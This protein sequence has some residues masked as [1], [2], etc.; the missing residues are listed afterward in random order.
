MQAANTLIK[1]TSIDRFC[2]MR[3]HV[4]TE[5]EIDDLRNAR[6]VTTANGYGQIEE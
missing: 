3:W 6:A 2:C 4:E 5:I 1:D